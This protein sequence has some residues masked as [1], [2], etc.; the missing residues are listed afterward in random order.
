MKFPFP[1]F[2]KKSK[3]LDQEIADA[4]PR[5]IPTF[6]EERPVINWSV[7]E[8]APMPGLELLPEQ[9]E[10][11]RDNFTIPVAPPTPESPPLANTEGK[12]EAM[13]FS[14]APVAPSLQEAN[15]KQEPLIEPQIIEKVAVLQEEPLKPLEIE[16]LLMAQPLVIPEVIPE[17]IPDTDP[18]ITSNLTVSVKPVAENAQ[19]SVASPIVMPLANTSAPLLMTREDVIAAYKIFLN[20]LPESFEVIQSRVNS[21]VEANLID[22]ALADEFIKRADLPVIIFP[23]VKKIL[24]SQDQSQPNLNTPSQP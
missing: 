2:G 1:F 3:S 19:A 17:F 13:K 11:R 14:G 22:F 12:K 24:E 6:E 9:P 15:P 4:L 18:N 8:V 20:R 7:V 21:S 10:E 16:D 5:D 23:I